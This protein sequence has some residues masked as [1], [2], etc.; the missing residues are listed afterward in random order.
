MGKVPVDRLPWSGDCKAL[1]GL[2]WILAIAVCAP[3]L[4]G[5]PF[6]PPPAGT[7]RPLGQKGRAPWIALEAWWWRASPEAPWQDLGLHVQQAQ[8]PSAWGTWMGSG[9]GSQWGP[10]TRWHVT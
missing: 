8:L 2:A 4:L 1:A 10:G 9:R 5:L 6:P 3:V 7:S